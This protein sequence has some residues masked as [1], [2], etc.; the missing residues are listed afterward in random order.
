MS[1]GAYD[2][3]YALVDEMANKIVRE[4]YESNRRRLFADLMR[5]MAEAM[6][7]I[8]W[9][10]SDDSSEEDANIAIDKVFSFFD[11]N[12]HSMYKI[13]GF[14]TIKQI[15]VKIEDDK[16]QQMRQ[17]GSTNYTF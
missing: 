17:G 12:L 16:Y 10:D 3:T 8:E 2:Y 7:V 6:K 13:A 9:V 1:G 5:L 4:N 15:I 14:D 11:V